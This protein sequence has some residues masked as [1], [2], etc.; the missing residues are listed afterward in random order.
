[1]ISNI[2]NRHPQV[3]SL[4]EFF[5]TVGDRAFLKRQ[6]TGSWMWRHYRGQSPRLS[7]VLR[8]STEE[9]LYPVDNPNARF[10]RESVPPILCSALP[11]ITDDYE[12]LFDELGPLV[13]AQSR[14][15]PADHFRFL[16]EW[17]CERFGHEVWVERSGG[18]L[19]YGSILLREFPDARVIHVYRDGRDTAISMSRHYLFRTFLA[20][21]KKLQGG[22]D[23]NIT[24]FMTRRERWPNL[25]AFME[26]LFNPMIKPERLPYDELTLTDFALFWNGLVEFS[27]K[28]FA[29][30]P[31]ER[32]LQVRFEDV[33][34][35]PETELQRL[36]RFI[37]PSLEDNAWLRAAC[38]IPRPSSS[39]FTL[40]EPDIQTAVSRACRSGLELLGYPV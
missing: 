36:I 15:A 11:H 38:A 37:D 8:E 29:D 6:R 4:S 1:M 40:L 9:L 21:L 31:A 5:S 10:N 20:A 34:R 30:L 27:H 18:S 13:C 2:L 39:K 7:R 22:G 28:L 24:A 16:F 19:I 25:S 17:L 14:Q 23:I 3:L 32:I 12:A 35:N 33:Q 26:T